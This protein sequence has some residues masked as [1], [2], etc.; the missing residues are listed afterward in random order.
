MS[1]SKRKHL[2]SGEKVALRLTL[3]QVDLIVG[4]T[5]IG[6]E[7]L[8]VLHAARVQDSV[9]VARCT[10][11]HLD[12]LAKH[13]ESEASNTN[14]EK[15]REELVAISDAIRTLEQSYCDDSSLHQAPRPGNV[16]EI[17]SALTRGR[18]RRA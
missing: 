2:K 13:V 8:D 9:V 7:L 11:A 15:F 14:D 6:G 17:A 18:R 4:Q 3:A 12:R 1:S 5:F 10:L 16:R